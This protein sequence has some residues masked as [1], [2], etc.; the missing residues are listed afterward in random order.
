[1][2]GSAP[3]LKN[4]IIN[5]NVVDVA[6]LQKRNIFMGFDPVGTTG[7]LYALS[8]GSVLFLPALVT[9]QAGPDRVDLPAVTMKSR[10]KSP[11][12]S[13][14]AVCPRTTPTAASF[15]WEAMVTPTTPSL[16]DTAPASGTCGWIP[17]STPRRRR[18]WRWPRF[19]L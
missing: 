9:A 5:N 19:R 8:V 7:L 1:M 14:S 16:R 10:K 13:S 18:S 3:L 2:G 17:L 12:S 15:S 6:A 4:T 11:K